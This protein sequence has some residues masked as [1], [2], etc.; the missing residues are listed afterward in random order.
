MTDYTVLPD[1]TFSEGNPIRGID[2]IALRDN[3]TAI[4]E[5][6][7]GA[8][9]IQNAALASDS[10]TAAKI[11]ANAVG[12]SEI[13]AGAVGNSELAS[14]AVTAAKINVSSFTN[15]SLGT[16]IV[17]AQDNGNNFSYFV[18]ASVPASNIKNVSSG[19]WRVMGTNAYT[20]SSENG[21]SLALLLRIA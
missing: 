2:G 21:G 19:T 3:P 8:P 11:A 14:N 5:G 18:G 12:A 15:Y 4:A 17:T 1:S 6:A 7:A 16:Y 20:Y 10:V 9:R 13:A